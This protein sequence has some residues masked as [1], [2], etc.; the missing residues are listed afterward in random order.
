MAGALDGILD[1][2]KAGLSEAVGKAWGCPGTKCSHV[3][4]ASCGA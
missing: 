1:A 4:H 3:Q 2:F